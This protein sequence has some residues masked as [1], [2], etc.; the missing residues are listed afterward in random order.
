MS[1]F[2]TKI[3]VLALL[4]LC[5]QS[6]KSQDLPSHAELENLLDRAERQSQNYVRVFQNL[7]AE[8]IKTKFYY[9]PNG[10]LDEKRVIKSLF[11]VY[12]SRDAKSVQE[13]RNVLEFNGKDVSRNERE[14]AKFFARLAKA[15][16]TDEEYERIRKESLRY[17][18]SRTSWG[19]TL[20]QPRPFAEK[21]RASFE[22]RVAGRKK[23]EERDV[24]VIEYEQTKP[25]PY[26]LSN[27]TEEEL[28]LRGA[29]QYN[30]PISG[31]FQPTNPRLKGE[32]LLDTETGQIW[33]NEF[34]VVL[35]PA[36]LSRPVEATQIA[37]EYQASEFGILVPKK[38]L[39][40]SFTIKGKSDEDLK[41]I[42]DVETV[43]EYSKFSEF[44][45]EAKEFKA[46][47][48]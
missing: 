31:A 10:A 40:R 4:F 23:V 7:S 19:M 15:E 1:N 38:F 28:R 20:S 17:D 12:P 30:M 45:T 18:G 16:T 47:Y 43:Y 42:K 32:L 3:F 33:R 9:K 46:E 35:H 5:F 11:V 22:F 2:G 6:A 14:T 36:I 25:S 34:R 41:V 21:T 27:P 13:F 29:T 48:Q 26:I 44:K 39:I 37:Y 24:W 8:E